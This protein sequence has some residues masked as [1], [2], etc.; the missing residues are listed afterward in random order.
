MSTNAQKIHIFQIKFKKGA[1]SNVLH[2][3]Y[4]LM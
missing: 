3:I 2:S 4:M 1:G